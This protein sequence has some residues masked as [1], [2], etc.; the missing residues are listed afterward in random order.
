MNRIGRGIGSFLMCVVIAVGTIEGQKG[1][2][3]R[4][5]TVR[6]KVTVTVTVRTT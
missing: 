5:V 1:V 2:M 3:M 6:T 4:T